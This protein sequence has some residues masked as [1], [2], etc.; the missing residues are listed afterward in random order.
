MRQLCYHV[1]GMMVL[2]LNKIRY[3]LRG[4]REP[5]PFAPTEIDRAIAYDQS[6]V[7]HWL[8][9]L[10]AY[11]GQTVDGKVVLEL[12][13][14]AD[15]GPALFLLD[16]G[17]KSYVTVDAN[18]LIDQAPRAFYDSLLARLTHGED[19]REQLN[20]T[21]S[22]QDDRIRY[23]VE[24]NFDLAVL[25]GRSVDLVV[26]QAA[27]E[28]FDDVERTIG[29]LSKIV[30]PGGILIAEVD[31]MTHT[32]LLRTRDPL[33]IYRYP[34]WIYRLMHFVG[35]PNRLRPND[36]KEIFEKYGW[37]DVQIRPLQQLSKQDE[38]KVRPHLATVYRAEEAQMHVLSILIC[39]TRL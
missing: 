19:L 26:S 6:V 28:H 33:N 32:G 2:I 10:R 16:R 17:A 18:R 36:Y 25:E 20:R 9:A 4:Y 21:L 38:E 27:F 23:C 24:P 31:L 39:A 29:Q 8:D 35:I 1:L 14:G 37:K 22:N 7:D 15:L 3:T 13:P 34:N 5:R 30:H 11:N 12:G